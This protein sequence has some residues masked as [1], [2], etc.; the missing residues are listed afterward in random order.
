LAKTYYEAI[1]KEKHFKRIETVSAVKPGDI[2]AIRYRP[3]DAENRDHNTGHIMLVV[4]SPE[5]RNPSPPR[6]E[7]TQQWEIRIIDQ[8][9]SGHGPADT[10]HRPGRKELS[11]LGEGVLRIYARIDG[12]IAGYSWSTLKNS[13]YHDRAER[14][15]LIG[16][17]QPT[18][19]K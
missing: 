11:G 15:I 10:R 7:E 8:S 14:D 16:R 2:I 13:E 9:R 17:F 5:R 3:G 19:D 6:V 18:S 4:T 12:T 1:R